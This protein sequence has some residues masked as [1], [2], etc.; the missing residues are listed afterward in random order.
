MGHDVLAADL[1]ASGALVRPYEEAIPME[2]AYYFR[3]AAD[4]AQTPATR[5]FSE[6]LKEE[7]RME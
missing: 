3:D 7:M 4:H 1:L 6:W 5:A 2:E